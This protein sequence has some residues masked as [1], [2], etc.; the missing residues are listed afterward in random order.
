MLTFDRNGTLTD[1]RHFPINFGVSV[2]FLQSPAERVYYGMYIYGNAAVLL[3]V[4]IVIIIIVSFWLN[5]R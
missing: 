3:N 5:G 4:Y 2:R 1:G